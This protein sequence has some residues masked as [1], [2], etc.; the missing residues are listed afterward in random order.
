MRDALRRSDKKAAWASECP[1]CIGVYLPADGIHDLK[2]HDEIRRW[3]GLRMDVTDHGRSDDNSSDQCD[4]M[5]V[6]SSHHFVLQLDDL[7]TA[8]AVWGR[9]INVFTPNGLMVLTPSIRR[10]VAL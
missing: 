1:C 3:L 8:Y 6:V 5:P 7:R 4:C 2:F 10:L 9:W